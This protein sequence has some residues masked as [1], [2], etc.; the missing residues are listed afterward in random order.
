DRGA[1]A[2]TAELAEQALRLTPRDQADERRRRALAAAHA[3]LAAGEWTRARSIT[4]DLLAG[5]RGPLRAEALLVLAEF[6]HDDLAVPRLDEAVREAASH[7]ALQALIHIRLAA[8]GR[9]RQVFA[10]ALDG[11]RAARVLR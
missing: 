5:T 7:P 1:P 2:A 10:G 6:P 9:L 3:H 4:T 8:A 11:T